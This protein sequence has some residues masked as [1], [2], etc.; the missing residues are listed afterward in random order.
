MFL[1]RINSFGKKPKQTKKQH[2]E[3][4]EPI[5]IIARH[6]NETTLAYTHIGID[7]FLWL[8]LSKF[9]ESWWKYQIF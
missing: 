2:T 8:L 4:T 1:I 9:P 7:Y 3:K 6:L 5:F